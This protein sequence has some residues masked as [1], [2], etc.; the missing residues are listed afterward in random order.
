MTLPARQPKPIKNIN[1][2]YAESA[3][4]KIRGY[5]LA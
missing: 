2:E 1:A 3:E 4:K 5:G